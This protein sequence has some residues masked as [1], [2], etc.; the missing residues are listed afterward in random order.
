M[1]KDLSPK[2]KQHYLDVKR[3]KVESSNIVSVGHSGDDS[4]FL[5]VEFHC[6]GKKENDVWAYYPVT[7]Q[8]FSLMVQAESV[9]KYFN[10]NI[11][12]HPHINGFKLTL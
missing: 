9:G 11:K 2:A 6:H 4:K 3:I 8:A 12:T 1:A 7:A 5:T 10:E